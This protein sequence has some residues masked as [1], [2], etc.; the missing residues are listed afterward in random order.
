[1]TPQNILHKTVRRNEEFA[2]LL[3]D[4]GLMER[5]GS[6][7]PMMYDVLTSHARGCRLWRTG[8]TA[9]PSPCRAASSGLN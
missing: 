5:E 9:F 3:H 7:Y 4:L 8:K 6:G 2:R 1:M